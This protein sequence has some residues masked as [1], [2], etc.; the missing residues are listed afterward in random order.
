MLTG[1]AGLMQSLP[2]SIQ[3]A[4]AINPEP[5]T[6]VFDAEHIVFLMQENRSFD[7]SFGTLQGVRGYNDPRAIELPNKNKVWIQ[8]DG[9]GKSY[10]P[11]RLDMKGSKATWMSSLPHGWS[12]QVDARNEGKYDQ[13]L[14]A[15]R[16]GN[17]EYAHM[18]LT[19][20]YYSRED[21]PFYYAM[22][23]AFTVCDQHFCSSLT[24]TT[25]NRL[26]F[27]TGTIREKQHADAKARVW[28]EDADYNTMVTW[29]TYPERLEDQGISWKIYQNEISAGVGFE[30]EEDD[31]LANYGDNALEYFTQYRVKLS[32]AYRANLP[33]RKKDA[34]SALAEVEK[35]LRSDKLT[36][37]DADKLK[38]KKEEISA[39]L[40]KL[41]WE[42][43]EFSS[44]KYE[45]LSQRDKNI[46]DKAFVTNTGDPHYH[47]LDSL[48]YEETGEKRSVQVPKGD[49]LHQFRHDVQN[50]EL[51]MVSWIVAPQH[52]SDHPSSAW[53]G[54]WYISE[55]LDILTRNP[56]VWKKTVF[57]LTYDENDGYFDHV[58][59]FVA[60]N[61]KD[62]GTGITSDDIDSSLEF[63][64]MEQQSQWGTLRR[65]SSIGLG[66][67]VPMVIASPWSRGGYVCSEVF[68]HSSNLRFLET[69]IEKKTGKKIKEENISSW[70]RAVCGDLTSVF[71]P[72]NGEKLVSPESIPRD[73]FIEEIH[74]ARFKDVP[75]NYKELSA[76]DIANINAGNGRCNWMPQQEEGVRP[77]CALP[78]ELYADM[79]LDKNARNLQVALKAGNQV[80]GSKS[81]GSAFTVYCPGKFGGE[82]L[83]NRSYAVSA[84]KEIVDNWSI[85]GFENNK[86][87]LRLY[88]PNGF[89]RDAMGDF[90][91]PELEL[92][93][94]YERYSIARAALSG[95]I[96]VRFKNRSNQPLQLEITDNSY[97]ARA[98]NVSLDAVSSKK[99]SDFILLDTARS[100]AWYDFT[101]RCKAFPQWQRSFA[102]RVETGRET[103]TDPSMGLKK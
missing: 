24:G 55:V 1:A 46:H 22:A 15:K 50:N 17:K 94:E 86:Y 11:F 19:M 36:S 53:Y 4:L 77:A 13:W 51:P 98:K 70:R 45:Q 81:A 60:P 44:E 7:H 68:D 6:T 40:Q 87:Q 64:T 28:N 5:G 72:W 39:E 57:I 96:L 91:D 89:Y 27:W 103:V 92:I 26:Y 78:Y 41:D 62:S 10:C 54:A 33:K 8:T 76:E 63:V 65:E 73:P 42:M 3:K 80:F 88:G 102:G 100:S 25:P 95:N 99:A 97:G 34:E 43:K 9:T 69:W 18:P 93:F 14:I 66:Y 37:S 58:P 56:E 35:K 71:R 59:P 16:S 30:G 82:L 67:R 90:N 48:E 83:K 23:D 79:R 47:E 75:K 74:K 85:D 101:I 61:P 21:I 84:G 32:P 49:I 29:P 31:W 38:K 20:G 12:N 2:P 52:F